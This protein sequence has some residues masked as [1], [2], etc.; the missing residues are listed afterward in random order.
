MPIVRV[1]W[2]P[3]RTREQK[4]ALAKA[5]TESVV[6]IGRVEPKGVFVVFDERPAEDWAAG[7]VLEADW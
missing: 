3:G 1:E 5:I 7:G 2:M 4:A 6:T